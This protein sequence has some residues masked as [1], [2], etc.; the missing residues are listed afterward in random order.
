MSFR[1]A[2]LPFIYFSFDVDDE[3]GYFLVKLSHVT[4]TFPFTF[5]VYL[6]FCGKF[7]N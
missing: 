1:F 3:D 4:F 7:L 2:S 6:F 5:L